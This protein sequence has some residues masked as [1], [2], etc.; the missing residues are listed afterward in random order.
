MTATSQVAQAASALGQRWQEA[1]LDL[2][3][4]HFFFSQV[5]AGPE[6]PPCR[7]DLERLLLLCTFEACCCYQVACGAPSN[8]ELR[9]EYWCCWQWAV[10]MLLPLHHSANHAAWLC[11]RQPWLL[12]LHP[13]HFQV[14]LAWP[15]APEKALLPQIEDCDQTTVTALS[16]WDDGRTL[17]GYSFTTDDYAAPNGP[18]GMRK[19]AYRSATACSGIELLPVVR[20]ALKL[21]V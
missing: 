6:L 13:C 12:A 9:L 15:S 20:P 5:G 19:L 3:D 21:H 7:A 11:H 1:I 14:P 18:D 4:D 17:E 16:E 8:R 2:C 10:K